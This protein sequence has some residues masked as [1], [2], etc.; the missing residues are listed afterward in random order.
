MGYFVS[1]EGNDRPGID[2]K[3]H[4]HIRHAIAHSDVGDICSQYRP[5]KYSQL[6]LIERM[7]ANYFDGKHC[8]PL[9][10]LLGLVSFDQRMEFNEE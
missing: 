4:L 1:N 6:L 7:D 5:Q 2:G 8:F 9:A 10:Q 3:E